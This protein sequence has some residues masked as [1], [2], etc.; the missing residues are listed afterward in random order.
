MTKSDFVL[1]FLV[2]ICYNCWDQCDTQFQN[3]TRRVEKKM[4]H[5]T[6]IELE[7]QYDLVAA[8]LGVIKDGLIYNPVHDGEWITE[9]L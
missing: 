3:S 5:T 1:I 6:Q 7:N 2:Q 4:R 9:I 8:K